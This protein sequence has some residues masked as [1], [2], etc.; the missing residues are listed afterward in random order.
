M[1][2]PTTLEQALVSL[3]AVLKERGLRYEIV[4]AG[5]SG[6][7]LLGLVGRPTRDLDVIALVDEQRFRSAHPLPVSLEEAA[8]GVGQLYGLGAEWLNA[9]ASGLLDFGLP[10]GFEERTERRD[11]GG[12][13]LRIASRF[14]QVCFKLY[15][16]VDSG[17][18]SKHT[19]DLRALNPSAAELIAAARW[20]TSHDPSPAFRTEL[21]AALPS[22]GVRDAEDQL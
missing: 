12:L 19:D 1:L 14:D 3:G 10:E 21:L 8:R 22:F 13:I 2:D 16:A 5:G 7:L 11:Y 17:P 20:A 9:K 6:L 4:V 18:R 15:A